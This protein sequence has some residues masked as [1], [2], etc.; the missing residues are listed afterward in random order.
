MKSKI[1]HDK[2]KRQIVQKYELKK[3]YL[4][5]HSS[6]LHVLN[7]TRWLDQLKLNTLPRNSSKTRV[8]NRCI[9]TGRARSVIRKFRLSRIMFRELGNFGKIPGLRKSSW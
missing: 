5:I 7:K 3:M 4:K 9:L 1:L 8:R 2:K 6:N